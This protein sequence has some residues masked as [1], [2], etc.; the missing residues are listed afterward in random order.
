MM[1]KTSLFLV[2]FSAM[3]CAGQSVPSTP[4]SL[5]QTTRSTSDAEDPDA[6]YLTP[7]AQVSQPVSSVRPRSSRRTES[8][9]REQP[10][11]SRTSPDQRLRPL[12][13]VMARTEFQRFAED[14]AGHPLRVFGRQLFDEVPSTFAPVDDIPVP[15]NYALGPG[16]EILIR[17]WGKVDLD[18][19][20]TVDRNG[21]I[22]LPRIGTVNVAGLR[23][24]Q[25]EGYLRSAVGNLYKDFELNVTLGQL[26]SIQIFVL[27]NA[28]QPGAYTV[29]S[30]STLVDALFASGGPSATGTMRHIQLRRR[31]GVLTEMDLYDLLQRG[32]KSR[33]APLLPGDVI[34]IPPV[35][36]QVALL[37]EV[38]EPGIY[39][40]NGEAT[41][42]DALGVAGG[43]TSLSAVDRVLLERVDEHH[44]RRAEEF[45]LDA[46]GR[47]RKLEDGD[48]LHLFPISPKFANAV[49]LRGNVARPGRYVWHVGMRVSDLVPTR[50]FLLTRDY[51]NRQNHLV[52]SAGG[53]PFGRP[54]AKETLRD[55][56]PAEERDAEDGTQSAYGKNP[57]QTRA[58]RTQ[59]DGATQPMEEDRSK[60][61][62][63]NRR[64][65]LTQDDTNP[66]PGAARART[67]ASVAE[68]NAEINWEYAV[69]ER[70]DAH[71]LSTHL[72]PFNLGRALDD[73][74]A[75]DNQLLE[76]G[77]VV[78]IFSRAD[79]SLPIE[80]HATFVRVGGEV[81]A[82]GV[83]RVAP[84][85]TLRGVVA[86]AGGPMPHA[87]LYASQLF[88]V[89]T[90]H[91][92]E[93]ELK[94]RH[95]RL[96]QELVAAYAN[97]SSNPA[98]GAD[99]QSRLNL[100]QAMLA[101]LPAVQPT[102]RIVLEMKP[103]AAGVADLPD[104][105]LEDGD[106]VYI[107]PRMSTVQVSGSVYN[108]NAFR[109]EPEKRLMAYVNDAGGASRTAD[110]RRI[111][112]IRADGTVV[113]RQSHEGPFHGDFDN[114]R[115]L[116]GDAIVVPEKLKVNSRMNDF[117]QASQIASQTALAAAALSV[118]K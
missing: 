77:D 45:P 109:H 111:F 118:L 51:W 22:S 13:P 10:A 108:E 27:G 23:Y 31:N 83:Y 5:G 42:A 61:E 103:D 33:D 62:E 78:T 97:A 49:T 70:L 19:R 116:P 16:D 48:L 94:V 54:G 6:S 43:L 100:Q 17:L 4:G 76:V 46:K 50:E 63:M 82:P 74:T 113:S 68:N 18:T 66:L 32:D 30:L 88:R 24:E 106:S 90:R 72:V 67:L 35:G 57:D 93:A 9:M 60:T 25:L 2:L 28:R 11:D 79:I 110:K 102:G 86:R 105:P 114:I 115:L 117:I 73:P 36:A 85:E 80:Q 101:R 104:F 55:F 34:Y 84:G 75:S 14:V 91:A 39:E 112:V 53:A 37:D 29:S 92:Q 44:A 21:Q 87:Y 7:S 1:V 65:G 8:P 71:D 40:L 69:I 107:P 99:Q 47:Q 52:E 89:S 12:P 59:E 96:Q 98:N 15:A 58:V 56:R 38:K 41:I 3:V 20:V 26:R 81:K 64:A 95:D